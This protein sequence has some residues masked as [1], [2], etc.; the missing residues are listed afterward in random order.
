MKRSPWLTQIDK[1]RE[2]TGAALVLWRVGDFYEAFEDDAQTLVT[3][4]D[5]SMS[6]R[7][8]SGHEES[9]PMAGFPVRMLDLYSRRL[10]EA[11]IRFTQVD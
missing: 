6:A 10:Q 7:Q 1:V 11:G 2:V 3:A 8:F 9:T 4:L 5:L